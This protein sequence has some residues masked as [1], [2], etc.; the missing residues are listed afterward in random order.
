MEAL[1]TAHG[2]SCCAP[3][4]LYRH[5]PGVTQNTFPQPL[6]AGG[7]LCLL[8]TAKLYLHRKVLLNGPF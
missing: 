3:S 5:P 7:P 4:Q 8:V 1:P 2:S 6:K